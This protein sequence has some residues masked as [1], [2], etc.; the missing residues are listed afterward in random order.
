[1]LAI[2]AISIAAAIALTVAAVFMQPVERK[3]RF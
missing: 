1:M 2:F 3:V